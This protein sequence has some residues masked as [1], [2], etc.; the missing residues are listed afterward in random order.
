MK[1]I[2]N[3]K[4]IFKINNLNS[5]DTNIYMLV[6]DVKQKYRMERNSRQSNKNTQNTI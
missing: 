2:K 1:M 4:N 3:S 6:Y 5:Q